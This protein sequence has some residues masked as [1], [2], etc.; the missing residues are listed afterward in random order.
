MSFPVSPSNGTI[1][2]VNSKTYQYLTSKNAWVVIKTIGLPGQFVTR[3]YTANGVSNTFT[4]TDGFT[5]NSIIVTENGVLQSPITDA[6]EEAPP[7]FSVVPACAAGAN[8][9]AKVAAPTATN[10]LVLFSFT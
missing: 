9:S 1:A 7:T 2:V 3:Q 6:T 4:I 10:L 8:T 5:A